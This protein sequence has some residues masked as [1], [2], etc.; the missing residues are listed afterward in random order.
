[1]GTDGIRKWEMC[2]MDM[3]VVMALIMGPT[4]LAL[5]SIPCTS[6][7]GPY[8]L[9]LKLTSHFVLCNPCPLAN[10]FHFFHC[11]LEVT[12]GIDFWW[13]V[14]I[15]IMLHMQQHQNTYF[16]GMDEFVSSIAKDENMIHYVTFHHMEWIEG[17]C[18]STVGI[19]WKIMPSYQLSIANYLPSYC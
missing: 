17:T 10:N 9:A 7:I 6:W 4:S 2:T 15:H 1:M 11:H 16:I 19:C 18:I 3:N 8:Q 12:W 13:V 14:E 5:K